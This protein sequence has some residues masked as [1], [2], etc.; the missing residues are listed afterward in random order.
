[1][2]A[3]LLPTVLTALATAILA[4]CDQLNIAVKSYSSKISES[5]AERIRLAAEKLVSKKETPTNELG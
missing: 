1:M 4:I 2:K 5:E 3:R